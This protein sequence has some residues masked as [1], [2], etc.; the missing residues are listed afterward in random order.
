[1]NTLFIPLEQTKG[2]ATIEILSLLLVAAIIGYITAWLFYKSIYVKRIKAI[3]SEKDD[4]NKQIVILNTDK[5]NL[6]KSLREK[7]NQLEHLAME[8]NALKA[9][10]TEAVHETDD[11]TLKNKRTEQL[12]YEK[13]EALVNIAKGRQLLDYKG[14]YAHGQR[15]VCRRRC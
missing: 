9:L 4:L 6:Q 13:D 14:K 11:M 7:D 1:M 5:S 3:T 8:V 2:S 10:H 15:H 12:L